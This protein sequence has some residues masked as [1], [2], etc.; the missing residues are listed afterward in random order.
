MESIK[1]ITIEH[2]LGLF[3]GMKHI[4]KEY[5]ITGFYKGVVA[6]IL[7]QSSNQVNLF[8]LFYLFIYIYLFIYLY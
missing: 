5:G 7:K 8:E 6:T 4:W 2:H 1:T 3:T